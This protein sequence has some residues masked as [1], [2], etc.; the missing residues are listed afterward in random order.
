MPQFTQGSNCRNVSSLPK[1]I[2][3]QIP[4]EYGDLLK[5][6]AVGPLTEPSVGVNYLGEL[7]K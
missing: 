7:T 3:K 5:G 2:T 1:H 4:S 6:S